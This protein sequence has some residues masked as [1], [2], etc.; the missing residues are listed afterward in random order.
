LQTKTQYSGAP[1]FRQCAFWIFALWTA[2]IQKSLLHNSEKNTVKFNQSS[3]QWHTKKKIQIVKDSQKF[4]EIASLIVKV[5]NFDCSI[6][7]V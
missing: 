7:G 1:Q 3:Q 4:G 6:V 2:K 5:D